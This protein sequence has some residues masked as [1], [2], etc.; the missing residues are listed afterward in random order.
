MRV[1]CGGI[2]MMWIGRGDATPLSG[3]DE[4]AFVAAAEFDGRPLAALLA[5]FETSRSDTLRLVRGLSSDAWSRKG[6][7]NGYPVSARSLLFVLPGHVEHH[8]TILRDRYGVA[9]P[10]R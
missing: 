3:F 6:S 10:S 7:A 5:D 8:F 1:Y 2:M 4:G 9:I